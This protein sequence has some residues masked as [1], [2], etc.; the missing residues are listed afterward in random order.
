MRLFYVPSAVV[1]ASKRL[2]ATSHR[3]LACA[4][5]TEELLDMGVTLVDVTV[6]LSF[7]GTFCRA[8]A[9]LKWPSV[10]FAVM[11]KLGVSKSKWRQRST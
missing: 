6:D 10:A 5:S 4:Y 3:P 1:L 9:A 2:S 8:V 7:R 11:A